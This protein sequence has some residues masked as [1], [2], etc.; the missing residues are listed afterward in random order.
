MNE[1][2]SRRSGMGGRRHI[3]RENLLIVIAAAMIGLI[4]G[5]DL[6]SIATAI[7]FL[8]PDFGLSSFMISVV[9]TAVVVGQLFGA[10]SAGRITNRFGRKNTMIAVALGYAVFTGLQGIAPN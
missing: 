10:L 7:I 3:T 5:Y 8:G 4:Y 9:T 2:A 1:A 6:G